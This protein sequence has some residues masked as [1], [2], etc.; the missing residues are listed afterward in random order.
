MGSGCTARIMRYESG[1][2]SQR[3]RVSRAA[4][5]HPRQRTRARAGLRTQCAIAPLARTRH[6]RCAPAATPSKEL[7]VLSTLTARKLE[8]IFPRLTHPSPPD[9]RKQVLTIAE[10]LG[11]SKQVS[12]SFA[13]EQ[14]GDRLGMRARSEARGTAAWGRAPDVK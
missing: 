12:A 5:C 4:A 11:C 13:R 6:A 10:S 2:L 1:M 14:Q 8:I 3:A 7:G 9:Q